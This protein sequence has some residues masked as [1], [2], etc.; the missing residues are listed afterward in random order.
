M[1]A[2]GPIV[3]PAT[4]ERFDVPEMDQLFERVMPGGRP[5]APADVAAAALFLASPE[6]GFVNGTDI[7]VDG[8]M[9]AQIMN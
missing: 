4:Q 3:T 5:G 2:P 1:I 7:V 8:G 9:F 6:A